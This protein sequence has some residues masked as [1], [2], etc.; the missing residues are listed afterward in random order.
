MAVIILEHSPRTGA[1]RLGETLRN[2]GQ[3]LRVVALHE[4]DPVPDDL[5]EVDGII[6]AGGPQDP[7]DDSLPWLEEEMALLRAA[8]E[9]EL[10][11]VGLCLGCQILG[12]ALGGRVGRLSASEDPANTPARYIELGWHELKLTPTGREDPLHAGFAWN[13]MQLHWHRH[14]LI[15]PPPGAQVLA[16][17][18]LCKVQT[19]S[20]GVRTYGFQY[21]PEVYPQTIENWAA[22]E[23][24]D[25]EEA[26]ISLEQLRKDTE[27]YYP[28]FERLSDRLFERISLVL[29]APDRRCA[30]VAR[31]MHH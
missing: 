13:S 22:D 20:L 27:Q 29:M 7:S 30:G 4:G 3:S 11:V 26:G 21:H 19:W 18:D 2:Y 14:H 1:L 5:V 10:P 8:H 17:S 25:L 23:P 12:R 16:S 31:D 15:E 24:Q 9:A 6:S 28:S